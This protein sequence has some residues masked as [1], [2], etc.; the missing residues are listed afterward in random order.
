MS[1][2]SPYVMIVIPFCQQNIKFPLLINLFTAL[3]LSKMPTYDDLGDQHMMTPPPKKNVRVEV[4]RPAVFMINR[5]QLKFKNHN[6]YCMSGKHNM[7]LS[8]SRGELNV[9][10][11]FQKGGG[12]L[13]MI[14][15]FRRGLLGKTEVRFF[16]GVAAF[17]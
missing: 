11:N 17:T 8:I 13:D 12:E 4:S 6:K 10:P 3:K 16:W 5:T 15:I 1:S 2:A 7:N 9:L 14:T